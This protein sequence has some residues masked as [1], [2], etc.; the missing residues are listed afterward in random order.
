MLTLHEQFDALHAAPPHVAEKV[1][2]GWG[3]ALEKLAA[4]QA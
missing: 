3:M 4:A 2:I 1:G